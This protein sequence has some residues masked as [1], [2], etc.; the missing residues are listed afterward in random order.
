MYWNNK[1]I[2][3][4]TSQLAVGWWWRCKKYLTF[5]PRYQRRKKKLLH[6]TFRSTLVHRT[7]SAATN[8]LISARLRDVLVRATY[9]IISPFFCQAKEFVLGQHNL[10]FAKLQLTLV[11]WML[12]AGKLR[13][14]YAGSCQGNL[15]LPERKIWKYNEE[16]TESP[17]LEIYAPLWSSPPTTHPPTSHY[18]TWNL[19]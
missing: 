10:M 8:V 14:I 19:H 2:H 5:Y 18:Y 15:G 6:V 3:S 9:K 4:F 13:E 7:A 11:I 1:F 12:V 16:N 17:A